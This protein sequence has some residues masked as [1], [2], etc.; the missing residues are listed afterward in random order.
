[1]TSNRHFRGLQ[2]LDFDAF[3]EQIRLYCGEYSPRATGC[4][5]F[6]GAVLTKRVYGSNA[7]GVSGNFDRIDRTLSD[8]KR[9]QMDRYALIFLTAGRMTVLQND[10]VAKVSEGGCV[11][12][13]VGRPLS[14]DLG[15]TCSE[16]L[17]LQLPRR[18][19]VSHLG[20]EPN[21]GVCWG[22]DALAA[23]LLRRLVLDGVDE[24]DVPCKADENY[25]QLAIGDL[26][27]ALLTSSDLLSYSSHS[28]KVFTR[29]CNI[30]KSQ[31]ADPE[32]SPRE[33]ASEAGISL[34]YLQKLFTARGTT[35]SGFIQSLRLDH[36]A[37]LLLRIRA[38]NNS[39]QPLSEIAYACGFQEYAYFARTFRQ[40][41]GRSPGAAPECDQDIA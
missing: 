40:R 29:V 8:T 16:Y 15:N 18:P 6:S 20:L 4:G 14:F 31:F 17:A 38:M 1:M 10:R 23:R 41:F 24:C 39:G 34:R 35:C 2:R 5:D 26:L 12:V 9:D 25:M 27:G 21:G 19:L 3:R 30:V 28:D 13:D 7:V 32:I 33:V 36:A 11:L 22:S 37:R